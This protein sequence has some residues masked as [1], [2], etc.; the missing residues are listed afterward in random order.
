MLIN[1]LSYNISWATQVNKI[2]GSEADFVEACQQQYKIGGKQCIKNAIKNIAKLP[3]L[4][5]V[6]LQEV[7][8]SIEKKIMRIQPSLKKFKR[9]TIG[10]STVS[11]LWN[12]KLFGDL[13]NDHALNL[14]KDDDRPC[15]ILVFKKKEEILIVINV[16]MPW[17]NNM[18]HAIKIL[19]NYIKKNN[20]LKNY[21]F[22]SKTK[23]IMMGDFNDSK[24]TIYRTKPLIIKNNKKTIKLKHNKTKKQARKTLKSCCWH[25][26]KHKYKHF[27]GTGDY[28]L[29]NKNIKQ[30]S[31]K[32]PEIFRKAGRMHK[33]FS[34]HKP[35]L[36][37]VDI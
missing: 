15:L 21:F 34:D 16:H 4:D 33:L 1:V 31:L 27:D 9:A 14:A 19:E 3:Q 2:L 25:K 5:L 35:V 26:S 8:S 12:S 23:I 20:I 32:I 36:S 28:I 7:N 13:I 10:R 11:I 22:D 30:K 24:T 29:V 37:V 6:G 17:A 18:P